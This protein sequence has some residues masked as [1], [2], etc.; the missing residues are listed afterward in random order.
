MSSTP[1]SIR[2]ILC[3]YFAHQATRTWDLLS[4]GSFYKLIP[5]EETLT[6]LNLLELKRQLPFLIY[7]EKF[8]RYREGKVTAA[9]WEWWI[10]SQDNWLG[11]RIQAKRLDP[12]TQRYELFRS[13]PS[14]A[15][16]QADM[17]IEAAAR[18]PER[19]YPL[20]CMYNANCPTPPD[21]PCSPGRPDGRVYGCT[22]LPARIV[23]DLVDQ[24]LSAYT[25]FAPYAIP[26]SCLFC[27]EDFSSDGD[28]A[29]QAQH[30]LDSI[31][32]A[33]YPEERGEL[34]PE[35]PEHVE[36]V[37][38]SPQALLQ[39]D[40]IDPN[41]VPDISHLMLATNMWPRGVPFDAFAPP[42]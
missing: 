30:V 3:S 19:L 38:R 8:T 20:Y 18:G 21:P 27:E 39:P 35:V 2:E 24:G 15:V 28:M 13:D 40:E 29:A 12:V 16:A 34:E 14:K 42:S 10:A 41:F 31:L 5:G 36:T 37:W 22:L 9:D 32:F 7:T 1:V 25:D 17:L 33:D 11:L 26:W 6:D 4:E 23:R